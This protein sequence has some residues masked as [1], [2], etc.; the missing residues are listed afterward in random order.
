MEDVVFDNLKRLR[1]YSNQH[2]L[3]FYNNESYSYLC[4]LLNINIE[5]EMTDNDSE[6][7][8]RDELIVYL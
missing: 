8:S 5:E 3:D 4:E 2:C 1:T 7:S 6:Y